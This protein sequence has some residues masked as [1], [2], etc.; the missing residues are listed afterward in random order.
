MKKTFIFVLTLLSIGLASCD[1]STNDVNIAGKWKGQNNEDGI[2]IFHKNGMFEI[3]NKEG[4]SPFASELKKL[5]ITWEAITEVEPHQVYITM[6]SE[7]K[8]ERVPLGIYKIENRKLILREPITYHRTLGGLDMGI[9]R[10]E[11]PKDFSGIIKV[12]ERI[13]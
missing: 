8:T 11:I 7:D 9:S 10:Y 6:T 2:M 12:F 1:S 4:K 5:S 13:N 3:L